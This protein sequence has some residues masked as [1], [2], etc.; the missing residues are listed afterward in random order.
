MTIDR[1]IESLL[2]NRYRLLELIGKGAMG[3]VYRAEDILLGG[4][5]A[6]KFLAQALLN[7]KMRERFYKEARI[8]AQLGQKSIHIVRVIDYYGEEDEVPY[9]VMEYLQGDS[10]GAA[11]N[12]HPM[13]LPRFL[14]VM[15]QICLALQCAHQ[16][17]V[18][19]GVTC[20]IIH[21]DIKPNNIL[22]CQDASLG[23]LVKV[24]D[25]GIY[26]SLQADGDQT[27]SYMGTLAYSSPEQ[28]EGRELDVRSDIYSLGVVMFEMLTGKMPLQV[29]NHAFGSWYKAHHY[30][31]P[32]ALEK[33]VPGLK[34]PKALELLV[35]SCLAKLPSDRPQSI[36][37]I[38]KT[39]EPL[40]QRYSS[41]RQVGNRI[42]N[43]LTKSLNQAP[44]PPVTAGRS[45]TVV[46][47]KDKPVAQIVF[48]HVLKTSN[49]PI[50]SLW[51]ML[52]QQEIYNL[53]MHKLY[54]RI[55]R[56]FLCTPSPHPMV[57]WVTA[58]Y[59]QLYSQQ[60]PRWLR[61][62]LDLK[63]HQGREIMSR[64]AE[65]ELYQVFLFSLENSGQT[66]H[67]IPVTLTDRQSNQLKQWFITSKSWTSIGDPAMSKNLLQAELDKI[68]DRIALDMEKDLTNSSLG[69]GNY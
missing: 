42:G 45:S 22:V 26:K 35:M 6:V 17:I 15:R 56:T 58:L 31:P 43:V 29:E 64:L 67:I 62:Y 13:S 66:P 65:R 11:I 69:L 12:Y 52:P 7:A 16:G 68:K 30:Q 33:T 10:L 20:P 59:N 3:R 60:G 21:R 24:L 61:C 9:Y 23:E 40:E 19:E 14:T 18:I 54:N 39:L 53:Q 25:F 32:K 57:L 48:P 28:M 5:V 1:N 2:A 49:G 55:Y 8:C 44:P 27:H 37:E 50:V 63:S 47:P 41:S 46:W 38:L 36:N 4:V 34:L 51:T